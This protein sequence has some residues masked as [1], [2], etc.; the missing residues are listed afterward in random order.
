MG[1]N[2]WG[3]D[4]WDYDNEAIQIK[5]K[6]LIKNADKHYAKYNVPFNK[7]WKDGKYYK[8]MAIENFGS[9]QQG[10]RI[11][12]A[13]TGASYPHLVGKTDEDLYFKVIDSTGRYGKNAPLILFY[14]TP[15]QYENH[16]FTIVDTKTKERW[17]EKTLAARSRLLK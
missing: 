17:Y 11:R 2:D 12:N 8:T 15:E 7:V 1:Q 10:S 16:R 13:V 3:F 4:D 5:P 14:D 6:L 9:G